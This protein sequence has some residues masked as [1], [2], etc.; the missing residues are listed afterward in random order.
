VTQQVAK[1]E[2]GGEVVRAAAQLR[3]L[4]GERRVELQVAVG[5]EDHRQGRREGLGDR[6]DGKGGIPGNVAA[7]AMLQHTNLDSHD[8]AAAVDSEL[9]TGNAVF[10]RELGK[11]A[12]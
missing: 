5:N 12:P 7:C 8:L 10:P 6:P 9:R 11:D 4:G 1:R 3:Q 2:L